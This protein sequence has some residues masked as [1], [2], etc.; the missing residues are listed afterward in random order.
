MSDLDKVIEAL[1]GEPPMCSFDDGRT[2]EFD[3]V[4]IAELHSEAAKQ[5]APLRQ[6]LAELSAER[7][8]WKKKHGQLLDDVA[9]SLRERDR[10]RQKLAEARET[11][12][13]IEHDGSTRPSR[14]A[15]VRQADAARR[16]LKESKT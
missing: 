2:W 8:C 12:S 10:L 9:E 15:A 7:D 5:I 14:S 6:Q 3:A 4:G 11:L 1:R 16:A 13:M